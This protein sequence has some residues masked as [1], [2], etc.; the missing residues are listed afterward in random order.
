MA[1]LLTNYQN[2]L[3]NNAI[4]NNNNMLLQVQRSFFIPNIFR[5]AKHEISRFILRKVVRLYSPFN[6][7]KAKKSFF[8]C[9]MD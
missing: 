2:S 7:K 8:H 1:K 9:T 5:H 4:N 6:G 3:P